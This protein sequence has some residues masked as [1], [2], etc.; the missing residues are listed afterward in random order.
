M[1][2]QLVQKLESKSEGKKKRK[3][4][5]VDEGGY[6]PWIDLDE[7]TL[8][9]CVLPRF[10][11]HRPLIQSILSM[12]WPGREWLGTIH[13]L[14]WTGMV[15]IH[16]LASTRV[17]IGVVYCR[18]WL[19][20]YFLQDMHRHVFQSSSI[21]SWC[22]GTPFTTCMHQFMVHTGMYHQ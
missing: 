15:T 17:R 18:V 9:R 4:T 7:R 3:S 22:I 14:A 12:H 5:G 20:F 10:Y 6:Y 19:F 2:P 21:A 13:V 1:R 8:R 11:M 16:A